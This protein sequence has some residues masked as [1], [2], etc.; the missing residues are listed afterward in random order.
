MGRWVGFGLAGIVMMALGTRGG[1]VAGQRVDFP[2][3]G[4]VL[5]LTLYRPAGPPRGTLVR[6]SGDV[7]WVGLAVSVA[8]DLCGQGY[9]VAGVNVRQYLSSFTQGKEHLTVAD[10]PADFRALRDLL[11]GKQALQRPVVL[12]GVSEGAALAVLVAS[13]AKNHEWVDGVITMGIPPSA[14]IAWRW[15]DFTAWITKGNAAEPSFAP[16]D[17]IGGVSPIPLAMIQSR[18]DE[19]VSEADY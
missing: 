15:T 18:T 19:Y 2:L 9:I 5:T 6:G 8:E 12:S 3:R 14:E 1:T 10:P 13:D 16:W 11:S 4:K 17:F 7:G